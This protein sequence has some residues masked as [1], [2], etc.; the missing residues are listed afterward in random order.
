MAEWVGGWPGGGGV[1]APALR[2]T[3]RRAV[4]YWKSGRWLTERSA[5][6]VQWCEFDVVKLKAEQ[7]ECMARRRKKFKN[8]ERCCLLW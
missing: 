3:R 6:K 2:K 1:S 8:G 4:V 5:S 7:N